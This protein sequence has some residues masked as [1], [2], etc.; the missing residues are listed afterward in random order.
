VLPDCGK[1][2]LGGDVTPRAVERQTLAAG[3]DCAGRDEQHLMARG[4]KR[5]DLPRQVSHAHLVE[6]LGAAREDG[7]AHLHD[8]TGGALHDAKS[9]RA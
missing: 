9:S 4:A 2:L 3:G 1:H 7:G 6:R 5:G 8:E